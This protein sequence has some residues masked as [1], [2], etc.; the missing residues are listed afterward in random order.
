MSICPQI[1]GL[2]GK[3]SIIFQR[4][5]EIPTHD[6]LEKEPKVLAAFFFSPGLRLMKKLELNAH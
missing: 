6:Q 1:I 3:D 2:S 5:N 4:L